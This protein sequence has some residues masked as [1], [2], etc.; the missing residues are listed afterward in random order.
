MAF[1]LQRIY[2]RVPDKNPHRKR[3]N[4]EKTLFQTHPCSFCCDKFYGLDG[5]DVLQSRIFFLPNLAS[6]NLFLTVGNSGLVLFR[7]YRYNL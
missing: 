3:P 7:H 4:N 5:C 6:V 1:S 2:F